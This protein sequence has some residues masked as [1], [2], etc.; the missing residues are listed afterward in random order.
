MI[1]ATNARLCEARK[2][3]RSYLESVLFDE[4][5]PEGELLRQA[6]LEARDTA[7]RELV[8]DRMLREID[9]WGP[10]APEWSEIPEANGGVTYAG[11]LWQLWTEVQLDPKGSIRR[12]T[13]ALD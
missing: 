6:L 13:V 2:A 12:T 4:A 3:L 5:N 10:G 8:R 9:L 11:R 7:G 1:D